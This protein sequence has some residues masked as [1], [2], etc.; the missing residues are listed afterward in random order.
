T[1]HANL[2]RRVALE[3]AGPLLRRVY[4]RLAARIAVSAAA[5]DTW[6]GR[7]GGTMAVVPNGGAPEFFDH[8]EPLEGWKARGPPGLFVRPPGPPQGSALPGRGF[9]G[10]KAGLPPAAAAGGRPR[11][12]A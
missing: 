1:C 9:P 5:R 12:Q 11:R 6:Q 4:D 7:F 2:G 10:A 8:P 3:A